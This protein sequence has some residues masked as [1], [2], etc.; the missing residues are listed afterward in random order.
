[1]S[2]LSAF[3]RCVNCCSRCEI[4]IE[5]LSRLIEKVI[6]FFFVF[7]EYSVIFWGGG[8]TVCVSEHIHGYILN[9]HTAGFI[10]EMC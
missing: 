9:T 8:G 5:L 4:E 10:S 1:M 3:K 7:I 2:V 6:Y